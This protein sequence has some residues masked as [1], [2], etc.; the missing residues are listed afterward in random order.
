MLKSNIV[1][2]SNV[3][4]VR[5]EDPRHDPDFVAQILDCD[6]LE[7]IYKRKKYDSEVPSFSKVQKHLVSK[8]AR[9]PF[10][11]NDPCIGP[12]DGEGVQ[13]KCINID[14]PG[15]YNRASFYGTSPWKGCNPGVT[16]EYINQWIP[17]LEENKV[18]GDPKRLLRYYRVDMISDDE[19]LQYI[20]DPGNDGIDHP[21][22]PA[23]VY[24]NVEPEMK[25][26]PYIIDSKTGRKLVVIGFKK[27]K[28]P[29]E[30][31]I[32]DVIFGYADEKK[33]YV[34][35]P[36]MGIVDSSEAGE[37]TLNIRKA[38]KIEKKKDIIKKKENNSIVASSHV[39]EDYKRKA[40]FEKKVSDNITS[41]IKLA[42]IENDTFDLE[43]TV[44]LADNPAEMSFISNTLLVSCVDHSIKYDNGIKIALIDDYSKYVDK[45]YVLVS[46]TVLDCGCKVSN[47]QAWKELSEKVSIISLKMEDREYFEF[48]YETN[49]RWTCRRNYGVTHVCVNETDIEEIN[50]L[51]DGLYSVSLVDDG[52]SYMILK[53]NGD[54]IGHL[55]ISFVNL[56]NRLEEKDEIN[57]TPQVIKGISLK[58][59]GGKVEILG[60]GYLKFMEY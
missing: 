46:S 49:R 40:E 54:P 29:E 13:T 2:G 34:L 53:K 33:Q 37:K 18:Y 56:I 25:A 44:I 38:K 21:T 10:A 58:V 32:P 1:A 42:E 50:N 9:C 3:Y 20:S 26:P 16:Q 39:D 15:I 17:N 30:D 52:D 28:Y 7:Q 14:C 19:M 31:G 27:L 11:K 22:P 6:L 45:E 57:G 48:V 24:E 12:V 8:G 43:N 35:N 41:E 5:T 23:P 4:L 36:I 60:M 55:G 51:K 47:V 59:S